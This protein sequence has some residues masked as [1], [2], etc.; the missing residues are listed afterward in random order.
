MQDKYVAV[1]FSSDNTS[2]VVHLE[3]HK[4]LIKLHY[5]NKQ[6]I[7]VKYG[8]KWFYGK[9][10]GSGATKSDCE[11][12]LNNNWPSTPKKASPQDAEEVEQVPQDHEQDK[13]E[14]S[15]A[16]PR[17]LILPSD[18]IEEEKN[19]RTVRKS[20]HWRKHWN[21][22]KMDATNSVDDNPAQKAN[23]AQEVQGLDG[24]Q[25]RTPMYHF[26]LINYS[27]QTVLIFIYM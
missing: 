18:P 8:A 21:C 15:K 3:E 23:Q 6:K 22:R 27:L 12:L 26:I 2:T 25:G 14:N 7:K 17:E 16:I 5:F 24:N 19:C 10:I 20:K 1:F 9:I 11:T 4:Q 13:Q